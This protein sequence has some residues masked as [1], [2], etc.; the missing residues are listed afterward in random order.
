MKN[1]EIFALM[2]GIWY[3]SG[4]FAVIM[5]EFIRVRKWGRSFTVRRIFS[6]LTWALLGI[7]LWFE[8]IDDL[9]RIINT[10]LDYQIIKEKKR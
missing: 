2:A 10:V 6:S 5:A 4:L 1:M 9:F 8:Y 7:I 3:G